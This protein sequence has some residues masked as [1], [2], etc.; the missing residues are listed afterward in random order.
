M[1]TCL[2]AVGTA[3][4]NLRIAQ[5]ALTS[6]N[7]IVGRVALAEQRNWIT[8]G[9]PQYNATFANLHQE[10]RRRFAEALT[11]TNRQLEEGGF[12]PISP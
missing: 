10:Y 8:P 6:T 5:N 3:N 9:H 4:H 7:A 11:A 12:P 1:M 2:A